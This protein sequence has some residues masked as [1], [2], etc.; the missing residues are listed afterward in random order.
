MQG[1]AVSPLL[2]WHTNF[3]GIEAIKRGLCN[4]FTLI[5]IIAIISPATVF[6]VN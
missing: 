4:D 2:L 6:K 3:A 1:M 5:S